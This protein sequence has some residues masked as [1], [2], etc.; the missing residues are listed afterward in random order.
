MNLEHP[1]LMGGGDARFVGMNRVGE[2]GKGQS[3]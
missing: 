2:H 3:V 1:A